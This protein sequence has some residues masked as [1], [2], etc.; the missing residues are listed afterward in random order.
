MR[1]ELR[2]P[3]GLLLEG[4]PRETAARLG[5]MVRCRRPILLASVGDACSKSLGEAGIQPDIAVVDNRVMRGDVDPVGLGDRV[6][7]PSRNPP[8][9]IDADSWRALEEA[10]RLKRGVA[11]IVE[12][13]ED[14]L[15]L[16]LIELMPLGSLIAYGQ[17]RAGMVVVEVTEERKR[18]ANGFMSRMEEG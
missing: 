11:V 7:V 9:T 17:P 5:E 3:L 14:L 12:G 2:E 1:R 10:V 16:P 6:V 13:E 15:V 8:G 18:W 4:E